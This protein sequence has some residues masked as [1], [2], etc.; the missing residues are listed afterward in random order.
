MND[1]QPLVSVGIF[2]YNEEQHIAR[3]IESWLNQD[4]ENLEIL[5]SDNNSEDNT[6]RIC[7]EYAAKD[8]RIIL[9]KNPQ[10]LGLPL[11][12][13]KVFEMSKGKYFIWSSGHDDRDPRLL[14][15]SV[16]L[17]NSNDHLVLTYSRASWIDEKGNVVGYTDSCIETQ[18]LSLLSRLNVVFWGL[19]YNSLSYGLFRSEALKKV[20]LGKPLIAHDVLIVLE[21]S[22][23]GEFGY[24]PFPLLKIRKMP[25][26]NSWESYVNKVFQQSLSQLSAPEI[27]WGMITEFIGNITRHIDDPPTKQMATTFIVQVIFLKYKSILISVLKQKNTQI[28]E[29]D[30]IIIKKIK[31]IEAMLTKN[32]AEIANFFLD[33]K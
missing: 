16:D 17:M 26:Y 11:N 24:I 12:M 30:Y 18:G 20:L 19:G 9:S 2:V 1:N 22:V 7:Q 27:F 15:T 21:L 29:K 23:L 5:I 25:D 31:E 13:K 10:N 32:S 4:Y 8:P 6:Y 14:S 33:L 28:S 3:S